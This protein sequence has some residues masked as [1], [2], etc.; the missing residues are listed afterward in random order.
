MHIFK[1]FCNFAT[2]KTFLGIYDFNINF[3]NRSILCTPFW[4]IFSLSPN[5]MFYIG[6]KCSTQIFC[7]FVHGCH[8]SQFRDGTLSIYVLGLKIQKWSQS[9]ECIKIPILGSKARDFYSEIFME[10]WFFSHTQDD[11][12]KCY[13]VIASVKQKRSFCNLPGQGGQKVTKPR[14]PS[15]TTCKQYGFWGRHSS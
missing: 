2:H 5:F 3:K 1:T 15:P 11:I 14:L 4:N 7:F 12:C 13:A 9:L 6:T 8:V 10:I